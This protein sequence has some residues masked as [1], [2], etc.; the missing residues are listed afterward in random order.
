MYEEESKKIKKKSPFF[1]G[2]EQFRLLDSHF[3]IAEVCII[4]HH[5]PQSTTNP[6]STTPS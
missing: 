4:K 1:V 2:L 3:I 5:N 6:K